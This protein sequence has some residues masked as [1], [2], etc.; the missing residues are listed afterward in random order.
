MNR[1]LFEAKDIFIKRD[2]LYSLIDRREP[3]G[4][5]VDEILD[6]ALKLKGLGLEDVAAL[7][8]IETPENRNKLFSVAN[9]IKREIYGNRMVLFAPLYTGNRCSNYCTYC[10]FR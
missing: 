6:R 2:K 7:L 10:A 4:S 1:R 3:D 9:F 5:E 8:R